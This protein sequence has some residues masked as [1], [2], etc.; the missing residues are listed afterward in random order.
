MKRRH[1]AGTSVKSRVARNLVGFAA[2]IILGGLQVG[3]PVDVY[4]PSELTALSSGSVKCGS[5][6]ELW[7]GG[8][9][10]D[11]TVEFTN[12]AD[13]RTS[14]NDGMTIK[15]N[16]A[17]GNVSF[18]KLT[19]TG[20]ARGECAYKITNVECIKGKHGEPKTSTSLLTEKEQDCNTPAQL[21]WPGS[22]TPPEGC[23]VTVAYRGTE[24]C[25]AIL[26]SGLSGAFL[27]EKGRAKADQAL[28]TFSKFDEKLFVKCD[29]T[30]T[31]KCDSQVVQAECPEKK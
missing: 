26:Y 12:P 24:E 8:D 9:K 29:G 31:G 14:F 23:Y 18:V 27:T 10:C 3:C 19:C 28:Q 30:S 21:L 17:S 20:T 1:S 11:V 13:C 22:G 5:S 15:D 25:Q 4:R 7:S 2:L 16:K 6:R